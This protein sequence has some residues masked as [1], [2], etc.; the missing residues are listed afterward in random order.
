MSLIIRFFLILSLVVI[1][2]KTLLSLNCK[3]CY[4]CLNP[5]SNAAMGV[6]LPKMGFATMF[7]FVCV[8]EAS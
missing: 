8:V 1:D 6:L 7:T 4:F 3:T 2:Y 5:P